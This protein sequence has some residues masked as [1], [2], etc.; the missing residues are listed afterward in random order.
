MARRSVERKLGPGG[1]I[2]SLVRR[3]RRD[4][5]RA[6]I[7][8]AVRAAPDTRH[9]GVPGVSLLF[10]DHRPSLPG[11]TS[12]ARECGDLRRA[13]AGARVR[14]PNRRDAD[15]K[16]RLAPILHCAGTGQPALAYPLAQVDASVRR[17]NTPYHV[18]C[19]ESFRVLAPA[20]GLGYI[21]RAVLWQLRELFPDYMAPLLPGSR[22]TLL[23][24]QDGQDWRGRVSAGSLLRHVVRL[25]FRPLDHLRS[26]SHPRSQDIYGWRAGTCRDFPWAVGC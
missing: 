19:S 23:H 16:I 4:G 2:L 25:A 9:R 22:A 12:R 18:R 13:S 7:L 11:R 8:D 20:I 10:E 21:R 6:R 14:Y 1:R 26:D 3:N 5:D 17:R 15:S 24:G